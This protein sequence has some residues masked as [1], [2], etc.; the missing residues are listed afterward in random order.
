MS[1]KTAYEFTQ[2]LVENQIENATFIK[3][4]CGFHHTVLLDSK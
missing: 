3:V 2:C 4:S 1:N